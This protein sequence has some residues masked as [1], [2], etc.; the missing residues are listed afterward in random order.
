MSSDYLILCLT[1]DPALRLGHDNGEEWTRPEPALTAAA[2][3]AAHQITAPHVGCDLLVGRYSYPLIEVACPALPNDRWP[4]W[5][6]G[7]HTQPKWVDVGWLRLLWHAHGQPDPALVA[8]AERA[9]WGCWTSERVNRLRYETGAVLHH[10]HDGTQPDPCCPAC[11][12][13]TKTPE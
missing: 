5:H 13:A 3:P 1:H 11:T 12:E 10:D 8:S 2:N 4:A 7:F 6:S 9:G